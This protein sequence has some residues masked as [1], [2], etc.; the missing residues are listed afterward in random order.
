MSVNPDSFEKNWRTE[1]ERK[2]EQTVIKSLI[3]TKKN[4]T[5]LRDKRR[6]KK[7]KEEEGGKK[8]EKSDHPG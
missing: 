1:K 8:R 6:K 3:E 2:W 4:M 7:K 5:S